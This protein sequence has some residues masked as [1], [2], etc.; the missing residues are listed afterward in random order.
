MGTDR[1]ELELVWPR[2]LFV[3]VAKK[4]LAATW[5]GSDHIEWVMEEAFYASRGTKHYQEQIHQTTP[6]D[7]IAPGWESDPSA[8]PQHVEAQRGKALLAG[9]VDSV[10]SLP[11]HQP[12]QY[13]AQRQGPQAAPVALTRADLAR[14]LSSCYIDLANHGYFDDA[15]GSS[16][17]DADSPPG[18]QT[19]MANLLGTEDIAL[20]PPTREVMEGWSEDLLFSV[21]E[22]LFDVV[23][24]PMSRWW[25]P[26]YGEWYYDHFDRLLGQEVYLWKINQLFDK[27][28]VPLR[29]SDAGPDRGLLIARVDDARSN[30][31]TAPAR[32]SVPHEHAEAEHALA[33]WRSR[34]ASRQDKLDAVR[35][36]AGILEAHRAELTEHLG[37]TDAGALFEIA[38]RFHI[39]HNRDDQRRDYPEEM[40]DWIFWWYLATIE[41]ITRLAPGLGDADQA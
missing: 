21:V 35:G 25:H 6:D 9:L 34:G 29:L 14:A 27:S 11:I 37:K 40:L 41:L 39:R 7:P 24:R 4:A 32:L 31:I 12:K 33:N 16:R 28:V 2:A 38:N 19:V 3:L 17:G 22:A 8:S 15:F 1:V 26:H 18:G 36:L 13:F 30:L 10:G 23:A 20:W 5:F